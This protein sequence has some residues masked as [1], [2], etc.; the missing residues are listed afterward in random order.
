MA[1][2]PEA[3]E[4]TVDRLTALRYGG[5]L[6]LA[7]V[8]AAVLLGDG[9]TVV[10]V[11]GLAACG[12]AALA[13]VVVTLRHSAALR[14]RAGVEVEPP[15]LGPTWGSVI[16]GSV[17]AL[18]TL[19]SAVPS[20]EGPDGWSALACI[21]TVSAVGLLVTSVWNGVRLW[22]DPDAP[23]LDGIKR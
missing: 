12:A 1:S 16:C 3:W 13:L 8:A 19:L 9:G 6:V 14:R 4:E 5:C 20:L 23:A 7:V 21:S 22:R 15:Y 10:M 18:V 17:A 2:D 11:V